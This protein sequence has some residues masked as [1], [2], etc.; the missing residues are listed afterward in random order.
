M[1][2]RPLYPIIVPWTVPFTCIP[3]ILFARYSF[4]WRPSENG[5]F[6]R[7]SGSGR[8]LEYADRYRKEVHG[9]KMRPNAVFL[10]GYLKIDSN[11]NADF[12]WDGF[13]KLFGQGQPTG[14]RGLLSK[15]VWKAESCGQVLTWRCVKLNDFCMGN[16][17]F[18]CALWSAG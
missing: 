11:L 18:G 10:C 14:I 12:T 2:R 16:N 4:V 5:D 17:F 3:I 13:C 8:Q 9:R 7:F 6:C 15:G 1:T